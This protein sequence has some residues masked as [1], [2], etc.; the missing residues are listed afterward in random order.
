MPIL[1]N[2][3]SGSLVFGIGFVFCYSCHVLT[4]GSFFTRLRFN[5][6]PIWRW[7]L[8]FLVGTTAVFL[9][10]YQLDQLPPGLYRDEAFNGL[11]ALTVLEGEYPLYFENN[12]GREPIFIYLV[13]LFVGLFGRTAVAIRLAAA[14]VG[15]ATTFVAYGLAKEWFGERVGWLTAVLWAI[16]LWPIHLS[17]VGFRPILLPFFLALTFWLGT[18]AY[19][20]QAHKQRIWL[21]ATTGVV[22][23]LSFYSY[24][25]VR[26]TPLLVLL[27][28]IYL[29]WTERNRGTGE[30]RENAKAL[31][32]NLIPFILATLISLLPLILLFQQNPDL[33]LG[34]T[35]QVSIFNEGNPIVLLWQQSWRALGMF[36][37]QGDTILRHNPNGRP[38]FDIFMAIPFLIGVIWCLRHWRRPPAMALLLWT[39]VMLSPTILSTDTPHF[40][41]AVGVLPAAVIFPAIGLDWAGRRLETRDWRL[42]NVIVTGLIVASLY[43]TMRDY[44][45]YGRLAETA[46][47]FEAAATELAEQIL[48]EAEETVVLVDYRLSSG[49]ETIPFMAGEEQ[50]TGFDGEDGFRGIVGRETAVYIWPHQPLDYLP[51]AL[52]PPALI[53]S[54]RGSLARGDLEE[55]GYSLYTRYH[56]QPR[57]DLPVLAD[58]S[59]GLQLYKVEV[60]TLSDD[61]VQVELYWG[62]ETAVSQPL[63]IFI[64]AY[65]QANTTESDQIVAQSDA[66]LGNNLW[67]VTQPGYIIRDQHMLPITAENFSQLRIGFYN[68]QTGDRLIQNEQ[69]F[70][71]Y[72]K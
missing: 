18:K 43:L 2:F 9:R 3:N 40:L 17:R 68:P 7:A 50:V 66:P 47:L 52:P 30:K 5:S 60:A 22:Y 16:T 42:G 70:W 69:D 59:D 41:R 13:A 67:F 10:T 26:V 4:N 28:G 39:A 62:V 19:R 11:D 71:L 33:V 44:A 51:T 15:S 35:G 64:H 8:L 25:A 31:I 29:Y 6:S 57:P 38:V 54:Q 46:F 49:W 56:S 55:T 32:A 37:W 27:F 24:L 72:E 63:N 65:G 48:A 21:W 23:G 58:F 34:R 14:A 12:N 1:R 45:E 61:S 20:E 53:T 36:I